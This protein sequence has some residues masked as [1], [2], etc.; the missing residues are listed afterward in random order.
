[1]NINEELN[2]IIFKYELDRY[3][4]HYRNMYK[5]E[6]ILRAVINEIVQ[7]DEKAIF[8]GDDVKGIKFIQNI[9]RDYD[10]IQFFC[11][12][13]KD[14]K[15]DSLKGIQWK[16]YK[17]VYLI[18]FNNVEYAER[19]LRTHRILF[20]WMYNIF[21]ERGVFLQKEFFAFGREDMIA[22]FD[23]DRVTHVRSCYTGSI[24]C[25]FYVQKS[26]YKYAESPQ[27]KRIALEK[28]LFLALYMKNF[29]VA[30]EYISLL[31][32][33]E[34][35][36]ERLWD[37]VEELLDFVKKRLEQ[38]Q[39]K[40]IVLYWLDAIT[41]GDED[42]MPYLQRIKNKAVVF[43]NA[44]TNIAYTSS[45]SRAIFLGKKDIDDSVYNVS[46]FTKE[47]SPVIQL[48]DKYGYDIKIISGMLDVYFPY[49]QI[50]EQFYLDVFEPCSMKL[51]DMLSNMLCQKKKTFYL[52][53]AMEAH[54]PYLSTKMSDDNYQEKNEKYRLARVELDE[55]LAFYNSFVDKNNFRIY[56]SDHGKEALRKFHVLF[57]VYQDALDPKRIK[58]MFSL[59]DFYKVLEQLVEEGNISGE[60]LVREYVEIGNL[61][62]YDKNDIQN[63]IRRRRPLEERDF[64]CKGIIDKEYIYLRNTIGKEQLFRRNNVPLCDPLLFYDCDV[65]VPELLEKYRNLTEE[66]PK[67][68]QN[69]E[70]FRYSK[71]LYRL[72]NNLKNR[73]DH[74]P[75]CVSIINEMLETYKESS[76]AMRVGG[77]HSLVLYHVLSNE[78]KKKIW[79]FI[80]KSSYCQG[81]RFGL[82]VAGIECVGE[83]R[84]K[85]VK[86]ILLS[87]YDILEILRKETL[88]WPADIDVLDIYD[89]FEKS[90]IVCKTNFYN[91]LGT[92]EDYDVGFPFEEVER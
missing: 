43:E 34:D 53:H 76:V 83:L 42:C 63:I 80:D 23:P 45:A 75:K 29:L 89:T 73:G 1:M 14:R 40:D 68:M 10:K 44:F 79:G 3:Y 82:P 58:K 55:Q 24:Q 5:A 39:Q 72:Y 74:V 31:M 67:S 13:R 78:N 2:H 47:N 16:E 46:S 50:S 18:S 71:Y 49:S 86:A 21:E 87:S 41:Y 37:E 48:L 7:N 8:I 91:V 90:G 69:T 19:W 27:I 9:S 38:R 51:W 52:I 61:D 65:Y 30:K 59:L 64:G 84:S 26:R 35:R 36:Y 56:L 25:E 57:A 77:Y 11:Y 12:E 33:E 85:G 17:E 92:D 22:L 28:C 62:R 60:K 4:P 81:S 54:Y 70:K 6:K 20:K 15:L 88:D 66:Y 32:A